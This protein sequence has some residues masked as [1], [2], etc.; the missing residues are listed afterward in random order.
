MPEWLQARN[1]GWRT[2]KLFYANAISCVGLAHSYSE[3][4]CDHELAVTYWRS[5]QSLLLSTV[6]S[7]RSRNFWGLFSTLHRSA[8][9]TRRCQWMG[10]ALTTSKVQDSWACL[11]MFLKVTPLV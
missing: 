7:C 2:R 10:E 11:Q 3:P 6:D 4:P 9:R 1:T 5:V 8:E